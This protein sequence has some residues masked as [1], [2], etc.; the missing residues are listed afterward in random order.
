[1]PFDH[2][3]LDVYKAAAAFVVLTEQIVDQFPPGRAYL[4]D[5]LR[6]ASSSIAFNIAEGAGEFTRQDKARFYRM[7]RR[8]GTECAAILDVSKR[9]GLI[10]PKLFE[11]AYGLLFRIVSMLTRM[12]R[13]LGEKPGTGT[14][15]GAPAARAGTELAR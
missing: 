6:R 4:T 12:V 10:E 13:S 1:M 11:Q 5:Q 14:G 8:S 3:K 15:T 9:L 7:A 2:E